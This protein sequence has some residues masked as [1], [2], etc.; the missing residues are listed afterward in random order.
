MH[1]HV[2]GYPAARGG[3]RTELWHTLKLWRRFGV[4]VT[5]VPTW[6]T[7]KPWPDKL[8]AIGVK[9]EFIRRGDM[10]LPDDSLVVA[11][12]NANFVA[13][14]HRLRNCR[15]IYVPCMTYLDQPLD[16]NVVKRDGLFHA[17]VCQSRYQQSVMTDALGLYGIPNTFVIHGALDLDEFPYRPLPHQNGERFVIGRLSRD[18]P[19]KFSEYLWHIYS[20][21]PNSHARIMGW[22]QWMRRYTRK[23]PP[24]MDL[25]EEEGEPADEFIRSLHCMV[26]PTGD[27]TENWPRV[28]LEAMASG[29]PVVTDNRG[30]VA[31]M[32]EHGR[33]GY[34][35]DDRDDFIKYAT[36]LS[37]DEPLRIEIASRAR[38]ELEETLADPE[39]IWAG[40]KQV[41]ESFGQGD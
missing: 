27:A 4:E 22:G 15:L 6:G 2:I 11:F 31:E 40:W 41:F 19:R 32:I 10:A 8:A 1:V 3:A 37:E 24:G 23:P 28:V 34:L 17:Y 21:I 14:S 18:D 26:H 7:P 39:S 36:K 9:T 12:S 30:G 13:I 29:V 20:R 5:V 25:I 16:G 38:S 35:C 33:T